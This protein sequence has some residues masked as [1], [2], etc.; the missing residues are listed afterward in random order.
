MAGDYPYCEMGRPRIALMVVSKSQEPH[1]N[2]IEDTMGETYSPAIQR[3][4]KSRDYST[5]SP[6]YRGNRA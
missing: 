4:N 2:H 6:L 5:I 1:R 3:L